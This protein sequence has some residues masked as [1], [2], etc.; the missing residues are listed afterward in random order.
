M[1]V[2]DTLSK[3]S[4]VRKKTVSREIK[5]GETKAEGKKGGKKGKTKLKKTDNNNTKEIVYFLDPK[6]PYNA[7]LTD[8]FAAVSLKADDRLAAKIIPAG[9]IKLVI[10]SGVFVRQNDARLDLLIVGDDVD[11]SKLASIIKSIETDIGRD[12]SYSS[13][14]TADFHYRLDLQDRLIR[15]VVDFSYIVLIDKIGFQRRI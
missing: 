13:L 6:F 10:A 14:T 4:V 8:L 12:L 5:V 15:D 11:E 7:I 9:K 3:I 2:I 1:A